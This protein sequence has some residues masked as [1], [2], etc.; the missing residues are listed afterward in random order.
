MLQDYYRL[1]NSLVLERVCAL[2]D[3]HS[4]AHVDIAVLRFVKVFL[5]GVTMRSDDL[6][7]VLLGVCL[8]SQTQDGI[9][10]EVH[11][12]FE[13]ISREILLLFCFLI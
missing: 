13:F 4:Y 2:R 6:V 10:Q 11:I 8:L 3:V 5:E 1:P 7:H 12:G 9:S